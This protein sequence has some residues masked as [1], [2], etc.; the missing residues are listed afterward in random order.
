MF[1]RRDR[2]QVIAM[3]HLRFQAVVCYWQRNKAKVD[4][5]FEDGLQNPCV[6]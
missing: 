1:R 6:V 2:D 4:G 5:V 3:N